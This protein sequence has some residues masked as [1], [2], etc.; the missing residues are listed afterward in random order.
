MATIDIKN[1]AGIT[2]AVEKPLAPGR[3]AAAASRPVVLSTE[4]NAAVDALATKLAEILTK[5]T[6]D[7]STAT[8]QA[9]IITAISAYQ[10][11]DYQS[12]GAGQVDI[13]LGSAGTT[14]DYLASIEIIPLA[15]DCGAVTLKDGTGDSMTVFAGGDGNTPLPTLAS[16][17]SPKGA[18][19]KLGAWKITTGLDV[20]VFVTGKFTNV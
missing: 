12:I 16:I 2:V 7:P 15:A 1:A 6:S 18:N 11:G 13:V 20:E 10:F 5:L 17:F 19:S 4:D 3:V 14:G 8:G 9:S